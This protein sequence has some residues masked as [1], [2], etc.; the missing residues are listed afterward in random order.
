MEFKA[1]YFAAGAIAIAFCMLTDGYILQNIQSEN[2]TVVSIPSQAGHSTEAVFF[3]DGVQSSSSLRVKAVL[4]VLQ[5]NGRDVYAFNYDQNLFVAKNVIRTILTTA[6]QYKK[7]TLIGISMGG[8]LAA[9]TVL[10]AE[11]QKLPIGFQVILV[12]APSGGADLQNSNASIFGWLPVGPVTSAAMTDLFW[13]FSFKPPSM[14][15][16]QPGPDTTTLQQDWDVARHYPLNGWAGEIHYIVNHPAFTSGAL[17]HIPMVYL[18]CKDDAMVKASSYDEWS[19]LVGGLLPHM[20][21]DS[22]HAALLEFPE[23]WQAAF[24]WAFSILPR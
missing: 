1:R 21:V 2:T 11:K 23:R 20:T 7:V 4:P 12:G 18:S 19:K 5:Q 3:L 8:L 15:S 16:I 14:N 6:K 24:K 22:P 17:A 9:D 13:A 10:E